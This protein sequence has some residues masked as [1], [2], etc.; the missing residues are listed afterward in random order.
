MS[1]PSINK[2]LK[3]ACH[4]IEDVI[5][6]TFTMWRILSMSELTDL[7][8]IK[9]QNVQLEIKYACGSDFVSIPSIANTVK[10]DCHRIEDVIL[11]R[12]YYVAHLVNVRIDRLV[13]DKATKCA[14]GNLIRMW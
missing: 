8:M 4:R 14:A 2:T 13:D 1:I 10:H 11:D 12:I 3:H 5:W 7:L 6:I 9:R